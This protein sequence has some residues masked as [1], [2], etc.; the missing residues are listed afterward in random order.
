VFRAQFELDSLVNHYFRGV[1]LVEIIK[2]GFESFELL[3]GGYLTSDGV[4]TLIIARLHAEISIRLYRHFSI[5][6]LDLQ[7]RERLLSIHD[8]HEIWPLALLALVLHRV[9]GILSHKF[10]LLN[11]YKLFLILIVDT[12]LIT[13]QIGRPSLSGYIPSLLAYRITERILTKYFN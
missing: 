7:I 5:L 4:C 3:I 2:E 10:L 12:D 6:R 13:I 8:R 9:K 11:R 1:P